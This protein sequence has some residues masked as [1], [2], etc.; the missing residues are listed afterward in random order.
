[1]AGAL[2]IPLRNPKEMT[3]RGINTACSQYV[4]EAD[5]EKADSS[6]SLEISSEKS[7][8]YGEPSDSTTKRK[9]LS[10]FC[11]LQTPEWH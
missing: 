10:R 6:S 11:F 2:K 8:R 5:L 7:S 3:L 9:S 1:M 4:H